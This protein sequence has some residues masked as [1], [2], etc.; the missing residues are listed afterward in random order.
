[1]HLIW[2]ILVIPKNVKKKVSPRND[3][4]GILGQK[5]TNIIY[6]LLFM[7]FVLEKLFVFALKLMGIFSW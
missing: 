2:I 4:R 7:L 3:F 5:K 1:M 6:R